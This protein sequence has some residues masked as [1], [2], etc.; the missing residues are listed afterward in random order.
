MNITIDND[1][2]TE[3]AGQVAHEFTRPGGANGHAGWGIDRSDLGTEIVSE[4]WLTMLAKEE[5]EPI[6]NMGGWLRTLCRYAAQNLVAKHIEAYRQ[7]GV[8]VEGYPSYTDEDG[9]SDVMGF[10]EMSDQ[11]AED[12]YMEQESMLRSEALW[13]AWGVIVEHEI[14]DSFGSALVRENLRLFV[15]EGK[16]HEDIASI[17]GISKETSKKVYM[18]HVKDAEDIAC[19]VVYRNHLHKG[20]EGT[21]RA[22]NAAPALPRKF[23]EAADR[24]GIGTAEVTARLGS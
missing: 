4:V 16:T 2:L 15:I 24:L 10:I 1:L 14:I 11:S 21:G 20:I 22:P 5:Q 12:D 18:R 23:I 13:A 3:I 7:P 17:L 19:L 8:V 9:E 6:R